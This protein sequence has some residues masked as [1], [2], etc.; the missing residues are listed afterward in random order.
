[1]RGDEVIGL[2]EWQRS[3]GK[4]RKNGQLC[5]AANSRRA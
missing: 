2:K 3:I 4:S 1:M 5:K